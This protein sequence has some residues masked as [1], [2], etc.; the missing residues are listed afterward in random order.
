MVLVISSSGIAATLLSGG[1]AA[2]WMFKLTF[3]ILPGTEAKSTKSNILHMQNYF[4][5]L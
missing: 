2:H 5:K 4:K 1:R 3:N